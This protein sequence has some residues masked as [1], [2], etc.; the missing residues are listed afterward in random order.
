MYIKRHNA[1]PFY[2]YFNSKD[3][4]KLCIENKQID[5]LLYKLKTALVTSREELIITYLFN[6][7]C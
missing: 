6:I 3:F 4:K 1:S 2:G 7:Y 5:H